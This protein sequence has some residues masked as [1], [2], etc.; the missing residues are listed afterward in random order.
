LLRFAV[1]LLYLIAAAGYAIAFVKN[2]RMTYAWVRAVFALALGLHCVML[3]VYGR[4][5]GR[6][7]FA[8]VYEGLAFC[9]LLLALLYYGV[10]Q[11]LKETVY[12]ACI[13]PANAL[14]SATGMALLGRGTPLP[15]ALVSP[16]F[17]AHTSLM[18][19]AYAC[20]FI[21]AA[22]A[23]MY[24]LLHHEIKSRRIG[25]FFKRLPALEDMDMAVMRI[26]ALGL[27]FLLLGTVIGYLWAEAKLGD[28][29]MIVVKIGLVLVVMTVYVAEHLLRIGR[30]W[31]GQAPC[32]LSI[33]GFGLVLVTL[34]VGQHGY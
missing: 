27:G 13:L 25:S 34:A 15:P 9:S 7:P 2:E 5:Q 31:K 14:L 33:A 19:C 1:P 26:D 22:I 4:E 11:A 12:G 17:A 23:V 16:F 29:S 30:G 32:L 10:E 8:T 3:A 18:F 20:F 28:Y 21:S 24:L 6:F